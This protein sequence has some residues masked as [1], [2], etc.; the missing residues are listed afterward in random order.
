MVTRK[1]QP[2]M[3]YSEKKGL[4]AKIDGASSNESAVDKASIKSRIL[5]HQTDKK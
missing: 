2:L 5:Q 4:G 1:P 3:E